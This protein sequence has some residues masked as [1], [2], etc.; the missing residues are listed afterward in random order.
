MKKYI[1]NVRFAIFL[2]EC[3]H[4]WWID[5][6]S[7]EV[8]A[9]SVYQGYWKAM[10]SFKEWLKKRNPWLDKALNDKMVFTDIELIL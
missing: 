7:V 8:S 9:D 10:D 4:Q 1:Y 2:E 6:K 3:E 5:N